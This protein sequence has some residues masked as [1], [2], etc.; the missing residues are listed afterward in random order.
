MPRHMQVF[1]GKKSGKA[2]ATRGAHLAAH[3][4][5]KGASGSSIDATVCCY[6]L[7][8]VGLVCGFLWL[9]SSLAAYM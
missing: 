6:A 2:T 4:R 7:A 8:V 1:G 9:Y 5:G 3:K